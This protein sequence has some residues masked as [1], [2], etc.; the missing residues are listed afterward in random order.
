MSDAIN[1]IHYKS[2]P[3]KVECIDITETLDFLRGNAIKS[4][5][6]CNIK[7]AT[8]LEDLKKAEWYLTRAVNNALPRVGV[9]APISKFKSW[10]SRSL[11]TDN[12]RI[13]HNII[14]NRLGTAL[15]ELREE[16]V[17]QEEKVK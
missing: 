2:H 17:E 9:T 16:I 5:W 12:E 1:P 10:A 14:T 6:R 11:L 4:L 8:P 7:H 15:I 13:I 3:S